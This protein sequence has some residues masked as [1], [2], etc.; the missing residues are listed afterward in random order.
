MKIELVKDPAIYPEIQLGNL[1][2]Y[3]ARWAENLN[4]KYEHIQVD[5]IF[6]CRLNTEFE[7][8]MQSRTRKRWVTT[9]YGVVVEII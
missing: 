8:H 7:E 3:A 5:A 9:K 6:L 2:R 4:N 1:K